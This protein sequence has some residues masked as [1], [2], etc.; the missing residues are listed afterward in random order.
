MVSVHIT[1]NTSSVEHRRGRGNTPYVFSTQDT[2][3]GLIRITH[4]KLDD[5]GHEGAP[6]ENDIIDAT[7]I[8][9][10]DTQM[11]RWNDN[12]AFANFLGAEADRER[13]LRRR[14]S[15]SPAFS[16][17][18]TDIPTLL[19]DDRSSSV[20]A[21]MFAS[22]D[23]PAPVPSEFESELEV[24]ADLTRYSDSVLFPYAYSAI[25]PYPANPLRQRRVQCAERRLSRLTAR[26]M[27]AVMSDDEEDA[28]KRARKKEKR[29]Q[30]AK[31]KEMEEEKERARIEAERENSHEDENEEEGESVDERE[32][33]EEGNEEE[34]DGKEEEEVELKEGWEHLIW[35]Q[36]KTRKQASEKETENM[37]RIRRMRSAGAVAAKGPRAKNKTARIWREWENDDEVELDEE[38][39]VR[40]L[41]G[42]YEAEV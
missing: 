33:E 29:K 31:E 3:A 35:L 28:R 17:P 4:A 16:S 13:A 12:G 7:G 18:S 21:D 9:D 25:T 26:G 19:Y 27:R 39:N 5:Y 41:L 11:K 32:G 1:I 8:P 23:D 34:E 20:T 14:H 38:G 40:D 24:E 42:I 30:R 37:R 36:P 6:D 22:S 2:S 15:P 10:P